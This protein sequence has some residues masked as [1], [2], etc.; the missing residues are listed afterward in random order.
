MKKG[1]T[2]LEVI[3]AMSLTII[4]LGLVIRSVG[5]MINVRE[6]TFAIQETQGAI[7]AA[8]DY[9]DYRYQNYTSVSSPS[10]EVVDPLCKL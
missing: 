4:L 7:I 2:L 10:L 9:I 1:V 8:L 3:L 6:K 5:L